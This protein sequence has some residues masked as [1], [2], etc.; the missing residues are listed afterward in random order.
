MCS[1]NPLIIFLS[2]NSSSLSSRER[3]ET[4]TPEPGVTSEWNKWTAI[5]WIYVHAVCW[6][7]IWG[8]NAQA[9][10]KDYKCPWYARTAAVPEWYKKVV[11]RERIKQTRYGQQNKIIIMITTYQRGLSLEE[12]ALWIRDR[13]L[14]HSSFRIKS[15]KA[16]KN[17][18][19]WTKTE[20]TPP[21]YSTTSRPCVWWSVQYEWG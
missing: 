7:H 13:N 17:G 3:I 14:P 20:D 9:E 8:V 11:L 10:S 15:W 5:I 19:S 6:P 21:I 18:R 16:Q 1:I 2:K 4:H 12:E